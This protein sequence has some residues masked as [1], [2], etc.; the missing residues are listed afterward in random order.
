VFGIFN[1]KRETQ[2]DH[3]QAQVVSSLEQMGASVLLITQ[4]GKVV[5]VSDSLRSRPHDW[6]GGQA[7]EVIISR[8]G[9]D[10]YFIYYE[11]EGY[12][13]KMA[14]SL[15]SL[16]NFQ[17][18]GS[19]RSNV[20]QVLCMY[21]VLHLMK[22]QGN[23]IRHPQ[24]SFSHNRIHTNVIA[25]VDRLNNWYPIQHNSEE[26]DFATELKVAK[27]NK[28]AIDITDVIAIHELSPA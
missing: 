8:P 12:Y 28:G 17:D 21:L 27:V 9:L 23:D 25:Y 19:Y 20:S 3:A 13:Y 4:S 26:S 16:S 18:Y 7:I 6:L 10:P 2:A 14:G 15:Q 22:T 5:M 24:M 1:R 11:N